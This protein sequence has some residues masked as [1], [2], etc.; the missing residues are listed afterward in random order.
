MTVPTAGL[1]ERKKA[2][3][4]QA[5]HEAAVRLAVEHGLDQLTVEAIADAADVSRRTFS[6]Y[7]PNK[8]AALLWSDRVRMDHFLELVDARPPD[9]APW[10]A[11]SAAALDLVDEDAHDPQWITQ[12][13]LLRRHPTLLAHQV[14][15][16]AD[17]ERTLAAL[18]TARLAPGDDTALRAR[19]FAGELLTTLRVAV[20]QWVEDQSSPLPAVLSRALLLAAPAEQGTGSR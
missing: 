16:Y 4:R 14:A 11:M 1:R 6:N 8:E 19:L 3:T 18:V 15:R 20:Q 12:V 2:A 9:E 13:R 10:L 17:A 7:F 5:L